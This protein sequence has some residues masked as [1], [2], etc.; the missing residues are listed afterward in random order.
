MHISKKD[1]KTASNVYSVYVKP[2]K[3]AKVKLAIRARAL[4]GKS[5]IR[6]KASHFSRKVT[7]GDT[8]FGNI[9]IGKLQLEKGYNRFDIAGISKSGSNF[10]QI[11]DLVLQIPK[12]DSL[13]YVRDDKDKH[14]YWGRRGPSV[15]LNYKLP[16]GNDI[17]WFYSEVTVPKGMDPVGSYF[18]A[19]GFGQG[20]FG[21]QVNSKNKRHILFSVW[22]PYQ[23]DNPEEIPVSM[24]IKLLKKGK[25]FMPG[26]L[27]VK[28]PVDK[29]TGRINGRLERPTNF[30]S[31]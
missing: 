18:M 28:V 31:G 4:S 27:A 23:T 29:V 14:F 20:Y 24:C 17:E 2:N 21:M 7:L 11:S 5:K 15:H 30:L 25:A 22:S 26:N 12:D 3:P 19:D 8:T 9:F 13:I 16:G 10:A 1:S 6:I